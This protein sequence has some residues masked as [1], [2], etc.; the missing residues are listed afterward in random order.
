MTPAEEDI[1]VLWRGEIVLGHIIDRQRR[2]GNKETVEILEAL[3]TVIRKSRLDKV[4]RVG[5]RRRARAKKRAATR[6][7]S[8][9]D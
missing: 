9:A 6:H 1:E 8:L 5:D 3:V 2:D 4:K 7:Y